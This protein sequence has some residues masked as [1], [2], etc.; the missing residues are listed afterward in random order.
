M[1]VSGLVG[2]VVVV[3]AMSNKRVLFVLLSTCQN[4]LEFSG[5][6][7]NAPIGN[8]CLDFTFVVFTEKHA[9]VLHA[10]PG[11]EH[12]TLMTAFPSSSIVIARLFR[13]EK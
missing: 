13:L 1:R 10:I 7:A 9:I 3:K 2:G 12:I 4:S 5:K 8:E 6:D 11:P